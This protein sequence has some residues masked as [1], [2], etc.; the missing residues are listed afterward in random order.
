MRQGDVNNQTRRKEEEGN[1]TGNQWGT[2]CFCAEGRQAQK[3]R[4]RE[5]ETKKYR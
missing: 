4:G 5:K 1:N 3:G 2:L